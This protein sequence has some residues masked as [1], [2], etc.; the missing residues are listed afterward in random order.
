MSTTNFMQQ[1]IPRNR[2]HV[3]LL[4]SASVPL[5]QQALQCQSHRTF[6]M[7]SEC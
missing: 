5:L 1:K 2:K 6:S 4:N 7:T 3:F